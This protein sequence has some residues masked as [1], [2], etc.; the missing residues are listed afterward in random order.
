[1]KYIKIVVLGA[2]FF[3]SQQTAFGQFNLEWEV[4][5]SV[6]YVGDMDGD[7][8]GEFAFRSGDTTRFY[9]G[10]SHNLKW[11]T[12]GARFSYYWFQTDRNPY[13][14]FPSIDYNS[15]GVREIL[16]RPENGDGIIIMDVTNNTVIFELSGPEESCEFVVLAD[17]DGDNELE[18]VIYKSDSTYVYSTG[19][20]GVKENS[21]GKNLP[22]H[23]LNQNY[24]N[25]FNPM[26]KIEY[27]IQKTDKVSLKIYNTA[28]QAVRTLVNENKKVGNYTVNWD[29][30]NDKGNKL[31]GGVYFYTMQVG[32]YKSTKKAIVLK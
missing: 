17:V 31:S 6:D 15:D 10:A 16:F 27:S 3:L 18:L 11:T 4:E 32:D 23:K 19:V 21:T 7:G 30:K 1:M 12:T 9:D 2:I 26:T 14:I 13:S 5:G 29:G 22:M 28:G 8:I 24:P 20:F 25:P